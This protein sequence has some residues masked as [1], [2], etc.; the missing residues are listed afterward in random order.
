MLGQ[1]HA[2]QQHP[3]LVV[4]E[5]VPA[6]VHNVLAGEVHLRHR[7]VAHTLQSHAHD[8]RGHVDQNLDRGAEGEAGAVGEVDCDV[9]VSVVVA[10]VGVGG[11]KAGGGQVVEEGLA[12]TH[13]GAVAVVECSTARLNTGRGWVVIIITDCF[14]RLIS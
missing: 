9:V 10:L 2:V 4:R 8:G 1:H 14:L 3:A 11:H 5:P 13:C 7:V 6:H 12:L